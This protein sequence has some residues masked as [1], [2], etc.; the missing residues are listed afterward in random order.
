MVSNR[1]ISANGRPKLPD[2][3][4]VDNGI[5]TDPAI[6]HKE[7]VNIFEKVWNFICHESEIHNPGDFRTV[8][9]AGRSLIVCRGK[10]SKI[11]AF[12]NICRHRAAQV[13]R[14]DA[15][16]CKAFRCFYHLWTYDLNGRL[17][18]LPLPEGYEGCG[19]KKED[20]GLVEVRVGTVCGL[21][22][23]C[24]DPDT[25]P[26]EEYLGDVSKYI[27]E[28]FT[29]GSGLE[30]FHYHKAEIKTNW[31]LWNDNNSELYHG[32]LHA[33][34]R[35]TH[36][37]L[38]HESVQRWK[39]HRNAHNVFGD[40]AER[41]LNYTSHGYGDKQAHPLPGVG[42]EGKL[43]VNIFPDVLIN[44]RTNVVRIDR[45]VP[46]APGRTLVEWRGLG[47][48]GD[49]EKVREIRKQNHY[50][51]WGPT[52]RNLPEDI[53][54]VESQWEMMQS[55]AARWSI[56]A[57]EDGLRVTDDENVRSFYKEWGRRMNRSPSAPLD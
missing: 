19:F 25:G 11:R 23:V 35:K 4:Y 27:E 53:M 41:S 29:G 17:I 46:L 54:A 22:F 15:G 16:N 13:V 45:M 31:K 37:Y 3:H 14:E 36:V 10:D 50:L 42:S 32:F 5:Y 52:G 7:M 55:R 39:L 26:L 6:F 43:L 57:R 34:N 12:Y 8:T 24:L 38:E 18:G 48:K 20:F 2:T 40:P 51:I 9:V 1:T 33:I 30:V 21:V 28:P 44:I 49:S 56:F 47:A